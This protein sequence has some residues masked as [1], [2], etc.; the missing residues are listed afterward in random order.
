[1]RRAVFVVTAEFLVT[2]ATLCVNVVF[3]VVARLSVCLSVRPSVT[4]V[5]CIQIAEDIVKLLVRPGSSWPSSPVFLPHALIP[6]SK[7]KPFSGNAKYTWM[8]KI[9]NFGRNRSLSGKR[10]EIGSCNFNKKL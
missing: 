6:T 10:Y 1:M 2:R 9:A 7:G 8:G 5:H 3:A 4:S